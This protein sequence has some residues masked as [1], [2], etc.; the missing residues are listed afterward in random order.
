MVPTEVPEVPDLTV[1]QPAE[2]DGLTAPPAPPVLVID[3][4]P[5][6]AA[7]TQA[8]LAGGGYG[9]TAEAA[10]DAVLRLVRASFVRLVV[11]ELYIPC[12]EGCC[13][14]AALKQDRTRLPRL[15]VLVHTRHAAPADLEWALGAGAD[16]VV[17]KPARGG[18]LLREVGRLLD[19]VQAA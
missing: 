9:V 1:G 13:V 15:R 16:A 8:T 14:V 12:A 5:A 2:N 10:G 6:G 4:D 7:A 18:V 17:P 3:D 11:S 19:A